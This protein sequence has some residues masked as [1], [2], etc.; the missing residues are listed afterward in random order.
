MELENLL[1]LIDKV[2]SSRLDSFLMEEEGFKL[3]MKK[4]K[5]RGSSRVSCR[6]GSDACTGECRIFG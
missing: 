1:K 6:C 3:S 5:G 2:S 4:K